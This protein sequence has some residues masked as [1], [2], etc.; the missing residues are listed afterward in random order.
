[1]AIPSSI[2]ELEKL[3]GRHTKRPASDVK[4]RWREIV[5]EANA[6]GEVIVTNYRR[7]EV[8]VVSLDR[9]TKLKNDAAARDPLN[10]L[11]AE[12]D[13]ELEVLRGASAPGRLRKAFASS[14]H[15]LVRAANTAARR[16]KR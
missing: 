6:V 12:F 7:P 4:T 5:A 15:E 11:R 8:V 10:S 1:M 14:P 2:Q 9:Y 13:R 16:R 3:A